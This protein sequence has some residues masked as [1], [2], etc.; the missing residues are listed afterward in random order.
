MPST[1][2]IVFSFT[3]FYIIVGI[4]NFS[5]AG[6]FI[7][8]YFLNYFVLLVT[9]IY[10]F[11]I[12]L[13]ETKSYLLALYAIAIL[14]IASSHS[15][16]LSVLNKW[17]GFSEYSTITAFDIHKLIAIILF[18]GILGYIHIKAN[19]YYRPQHKWFWLPLLFLTCSLV[20]VFLNFGFWQALFLSLYLLSFILFSNKLNTDQHPV[21]SDLVLQF[22]LFLV[23]ENI[24]LITTSI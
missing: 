3:A 13:K 8:P 1:A 11:L 12:N 20:T 10:S 4:Y 2:K 9:S 24:R 21:F 7:T 6:N 17:I 5:S 19:Q 14:L 22:V 16:T 18:Y 15:L 23:I